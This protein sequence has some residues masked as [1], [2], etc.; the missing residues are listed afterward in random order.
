MP[1]GEATRYVMART[2]GNPADALFSDDQDYL[3]PRLRVLIATNEPWGTYHVQ[4]LLAEAERRGWRLTQVV[5]DKSRI[6]PGDPVPT[7]T[8]QTAPSADL[9]VVAGA[10]AWP[11]E[12]AGR[13]PR[14]PLA[15]SGLAYLGPREAADARRLRPRLQAV[16]AASPGAAHAFAGHLGTQLTVIVVGSP[17]TDDLPKRVPEPGLVLVLTSVT[18]PDSTGEA[19]PG[20]ALLLAAVEELRTAGKRIKVG[21]HP[22]EDPTLWARY[23]ISQVPSMNASARAEATIGIPG[24]VFPLIAAVGTPLVG[25]TDPALEVPDYLLTVCS[26]TIDDAALAVS[27]VD[28]ARLPAPEALREGIGPVGGSAGRLFDVWSKAARGDVAEMA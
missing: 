8:P 13:F 28:N 22:R 6:S 7:A 12:V 1:I 2:A 3:P 9:L 10:G 5:P 19:A 15:A 20:T 21:L 23:E 26:S 16:T 27:A 17:R 24:T 25:C 18:R 14:L 11:V 4:P